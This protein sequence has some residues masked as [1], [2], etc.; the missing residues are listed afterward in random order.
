MP[1]Y[2]VELPVAEIRSQDKGW[3]ALAQSIR[4]ALRAELECRA[5]FRQSVE[6][7]G[8][9]APWT[10]CA[11]LTE[12]RIGWL[13][14]QAARLGVPCP[15]ESEIPAPRQENSLRRHGELAVS[16]CEAL[17]RLYRIL[18]SGCSHTE[19]AQTFEKLAAH[20]YAK[21]LPVLAAAAKEFHRIEQFHRQ[22]DVPAQQAFMRH[23][24]LSALLEHASLALGFDHTVLRNIAPRLQGVSPALLTGMLAGAATANFLK[25][26]KATKRK[27]A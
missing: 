17:I 24:P 4:A 2:D 23:G 12:K 13:R 14:K 26:R 11:T 15:V 16:G 5:F 1:N 20:A 10:Q 3:P 9:I 8:D 6:A 7:Y 27:E 22:R 19:V 18:I 25:R 21:Q